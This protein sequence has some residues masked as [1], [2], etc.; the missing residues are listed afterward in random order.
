MYE[1]VYVDRFWCAVDQGIVKRLPEGRV[2]GM[3]MKG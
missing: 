2:N 3:G 1:S